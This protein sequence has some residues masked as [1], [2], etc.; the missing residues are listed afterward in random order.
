MKGVFEKGLIALFA[1]VA[2]ACGSDG[3]TPSVD[4][5]VGMDGAGDM[6]DG[7]ADGAVSC[8]VGFA[9]KEGTGC[10]VVLRDL[11]PSVGVLDPPFDPLVTQY[12][13]E[14]P[15]AVPSLTFEVL[16][17]GGTTLSVN[18]ANVLSG[19]ASDPIDLN[20][21]ENF[22]GVSA[23]RLSSMRSYVV[24]VDR[25]G[26]YLKQEPNK[27]DC[28]CGATRGAGFGT[29]AALGAERLVMGVP[30]T[31]FL[32]GGPRRGLVLTYKEVDGKWVP[33][34]TIPKPFGATLDDFGAAVSL[35]GESF[36]AGSPGTDSGTV[37][38]C[39]SVTRFSYDGEMNTWGGA[40]Q[41]F[42]R[43]RTGLLATE[44]D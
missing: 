5:G 19:E 44:S 35:D 22:V 17:E 27:D 14:V 15:S 2:G 23:L 32:G 6:D 13:L 7:G 39:G 42:A 38:D 29:A 33:D 30:G 40:G 16:A 10:V 34:A 4:S 20:I 9:W 37:D 25:A 28:L 1:I 41:V 24:R 43:N 12:R 3:G 8:A 11:R 26:N 36:A 31:V 18:G 21:G